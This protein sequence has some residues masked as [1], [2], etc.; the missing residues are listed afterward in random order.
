MMWIP[1]RYAWSLGEDEDDGGVGDGEAV[2]DMDVDVVGAD[3]PLVDR[4]SNFLPP[5]RL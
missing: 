4:S 1:S 5:N 3:N 2:V